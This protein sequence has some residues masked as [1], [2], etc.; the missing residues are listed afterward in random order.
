MLVI[1]FMLFIATFLVNMNFADATNYIVNTP[2]CQI[3]DVNPYDESIDGLIRKLS[4]LAC[5]SLPPLT[6][7]TRSESEADGFTHTLHLYHYHF[8]HYNLIAEESRCCYA[9]VTRSTSMMK[10]YFNY[11]DDDYKIGACIYFN[12]DVIFRGEEE[13]IK[14]TC[15]GQT[16]PYSFGPAYTNMHAFIG[17]KVEVRRKMEAQNKARKRNKARKMSIMILGL[18]S[19]SRLNMMRTMPKTVEYLRQFG[20]YNMK[21]LTKMGDNKFPNLMAMLTGEKMDPKI[22]SCGPGQYTFDNCPIIWKAAAGDGYITAYVED[23]PWTSTFNFMKLGFFKPPTDYYMR[24]FFLAAY[25]NID[26][27]VLNERDVCYGPTKMVDHILNYAQEFSEKFVNQSTF[28][29]FWMN[30]FSPTLALDSKI[31][32]FLKKLAESG[33]MNT[34]MIFFLSDHGTRYGKIRETFLGYLGDRLPFMYVWVPKWWQKAYP[35]KMKN[36]ERNGNRLTS[37]YDVYQTM[38]DALGKN[39]TAPGCPKC[40]SLFRLVPWGR[41]CKDAG[42]PDY[43]CAC[44]DY[45]K[46]PTEG[47]LSLEMAQTVL[48]EINN[49]VDRYSGYVENGF[50]CATLR[51]D[52]VISLYKKYPTNS[53]ELTQEWVMVLRTEPGKSIFEASAILSGDNDFQ[54]TRSSLLRQ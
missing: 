47:P 29:Q 22:R 46:L 2:N 39:L 52:K 20:W 42:I 12:R 49:I 45:E 4:P 9:V 6:G 23:S 19:M 13:F 44:A 24:P 41:S 40:R 51:L 26:Q 7:V 25:S 27:V 31:V 3:P 10:D 11:P 18:D 8:V 37:H 28:S 17:N 5:S 14:V 35:T 16:G 48:I 34:T 32:L 53:Q 43:W 30:N 50:Q 21:G 33:T 15:E 36:L 54:I 1:T 38:V